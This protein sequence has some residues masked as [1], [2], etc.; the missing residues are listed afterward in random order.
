MASGHTLSQGVCVMGTQGKFPG[1]RA[2]VLLAVVLAS[3][4]AVVSLASAQTASGGGEGYL[5]VTT[6]TL[7]DELR[8]GLGFKYAGSG[9]LVNGIMD[10]S[11]AATAGIRQG[12]IITAI[13]TKAIASSSELRSAVRGYKAGQS[14]SVK[15]MRAG[16]TKTF[17]VKLAEMPEESGDT[18]EWSTPPPAPRAPDAPLPPGAPKAKVY[19][20]Y[21]NGDDVMDFDGL[22]G[23][24][25]MGMTGRGRL[26]VRIEDLN[27]ELG[28]Y[29]KGAAGKGVIVMGVNDDTPAKKAGIKAGDVITKVNDTAVANSEDLVSALRKR[30]AQ[31]ITVQLPERNDFPYVMRMRGGPGGMRWYTNDEPHRR[32]EIHGDDSADVQRQLEDLRRQLDEL[33]RELNKGDK[34]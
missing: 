30:V 34:N 2:G 13:G 33:K 17:N 4:V 12:D 18:F 8:E 28:E 26:G 6:Q 11:P 16:Q 19:R 21:G 32:I 14:V 7:T 23:D 27:A 1:L 5:G 31:A 15:V 20:F 25:M 9:A 24:V 10:D 3:S 22:K 29:F